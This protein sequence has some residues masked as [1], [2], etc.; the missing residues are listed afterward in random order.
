ML[1]TVSVEAEASAGKDTYD[2]EYFEKFFVKVQPILERR[3]SDSITATASMIVAAW[4]QAGRPVVRTTDPRPLE[5]VR[6]PR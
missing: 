1:L 3:L 2:D 5:K 4:D 6:A